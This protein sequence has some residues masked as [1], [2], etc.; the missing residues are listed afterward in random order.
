MDH[1]RRRQ[2]SSVH[3]RVVVVV[4]CGLRFACVRV[5]SDKT[6]LRLSASPSASADLPASLGRQWGGVIQPAGPELGFAMAERR[7]LPVRGGWTGLHDQGS[8]VF[9]EP[10]E[11]GRW[12]GVVEGKK[13]TKKLLANRESNIEFRYTF[14]MPRISIVQGVQRV[15]F[16]KSQPGH[17]L[18]NIPRDVLHGT[19]GQSRRT[20]GL[21]T[22]RQPMAIS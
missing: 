2:V 19:A 13:N 14:K 5:E 4:A 18:T 15:C 1:R 10:L 11:S 21:A 8:G 16:Y 22:R 6:T 3:T 20:D 9:G 12:M 7:R 17:P